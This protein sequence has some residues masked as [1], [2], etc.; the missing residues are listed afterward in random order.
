MEMLKQVVR[1]VPALQT[2]VERVRSKREYDAWMRN[3]RTGGAP[4]IVKQRT[5]SEY[6]AAYRCPIFVETGTFQGAMVQAMAQR[7]ETIFSIELSDALF[8]RAR[9]RFRSRPHITLLHGDSAT[10]LPPLVKRLDRPALFWLDGHYSAGET[11]RGIKDTP[12]Y[13]EL[14]SILDV[15]TP[16]HVVLIDD[17][18]CFVG[19]HDYPAIDELRAVVAQKRPDLTFDVCD[20][21]IRIAPA[22]A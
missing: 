12:I 21:I 18:R 8:E 20:D 2:W 6:A 19:Q 14:T 10:V 22:R 13:E 7:F 16:S 1:S 17:A 11:A 4:H 3:G 15:K 9:R 5:V